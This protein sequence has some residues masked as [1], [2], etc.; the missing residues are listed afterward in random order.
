M[1]FMFNKNRIT[2]CWFVHTTHTY[3]V[4]IHKT[5][6]FI[7]CIPFLTKIR[8]VNISFRLMQQNINQ[9]TNTCQIIHFFLFY[10]NRTKK[11]QCGRPVKLI[12]YIIQYSYFDKLFVYLQFTNTTIHK[13]WSFRMNKLKTH[14][15]LVN[16]KLSLQI[17]LLILKTI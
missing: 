14:H 2:K 16:P 17:K 6:D 9:S 5:R 8:W 3:I 7:I 11:V 1:K 10:L 15:K 12:S 13:D 4:L